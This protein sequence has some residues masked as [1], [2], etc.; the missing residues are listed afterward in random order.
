MAD[1]SANKKIIVLM[2]AYNAEKNIKKVFLRIPSDFLP[3]IF[4]FL[5][6]N[7]GSGDNTLKVLEELKKDYN[8][9]NII[10]KEKNEGYAKAQKTGFKIALEHGADIVILLHADGQYAPEEMSKLVQPLIDNDADIVQ[11]SRMLGGNA[12]KGGMPLYKY[13]ANV[14]LSKLENLCFGMKLG[15]YHSGYMLYSKKALQTIPFDK[16]SDTFHIDGEMLFVGNDYG[17]RIK[18]IGIPTCYTEEKSNLKPIKYG[19]DVLNIMLRY[20]LGKYNF[21]SKAAEIHV[22]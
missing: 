16:L 13:V 3:K 8:N 11:G 22:L 1:L 10:N 7:D 6:I 20:K 9:L 12:L 2:P 4:E 14:V 15:E 18:E 21:K 19:F 5:V 17:L